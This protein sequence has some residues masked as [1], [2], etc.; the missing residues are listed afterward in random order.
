MPSVRTLFV[1]AA[2]ASLACAA[3]PADDARWY[4]AIGARAFQ[5]NYDPTL[6]GRRLLAEASFEDDRDGTTTTELKQ[7]AR[8]SALVL[9]DLAAGLQFTW[10]FEVVTGGASAVAGYAD[11]EVRAGLV[12]R[13]SPRLRAGS[14][15]NL[16]IPAATSPMLQDDFEIRPIAAVSFDVTDHFNIGVNTDYKITPQDTG[17]DGENELEVKLPLGLALNDRWSVA[18]T[19]KVALAF[20]T[21][22][23]DPKIEAGPTLL[24]GSRRQFAISP[25]LEVPLSVQNLEW[26]ALL[27]AG[28]YY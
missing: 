8:Y 20:N 14:G 13:L 6:I 21:A 23:A 22:T 11:P 26:K 28:W 5:A 7:G 16:K 12:G 24:I 10:P 27:T 3:P 4:E 2:L 25:A 1:L 15:L 18:A 19:P 9:P 17:P